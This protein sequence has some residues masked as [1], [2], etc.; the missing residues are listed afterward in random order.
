MDLKDCQMSL[1]LLASLVNPGKHF[2][3]TI[4]AIA[5][6]L[7]QDYLGKTTVSE[8]D[9]NLFFEALVDNAKKHKELID[10]VINEWKHLESKD[11]EGNQPT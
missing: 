3:H 1:E 7:H 8:E 4:H 6:I 2:A 9:K 10:Q 11:T 5:E